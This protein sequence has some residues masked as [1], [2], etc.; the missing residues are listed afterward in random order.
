[1]LLDV[2]PT[3]QLVSKSIRDLQARF[4]QSDVETSIR[5]QR[6]YKTAPSA[7]SPVCTVLRPTME[8]AEGALSKIKRREQDFR[9]VLES[10][11]HY[12]VISSIGVEELQEILEERLGPDYHLMCQEEEER[13]PG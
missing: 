11:K 8:L 2:K 5:F 4:Q 10:G 6:T 1:M 13:Q 7:T 9:M 12:E 3:I